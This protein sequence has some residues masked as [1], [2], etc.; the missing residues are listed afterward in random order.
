MNYKL[1]IVLGWISIVLGACSTSNSTP[2][3]IKDN[4]AEV[5][6]EEPPKS[7]LWEITGN[8]LADASYLFG[9][10]HMIDAEDYFLPEG[11]LSAIDQSNKMV[12]ELNMEEVMD[13]ANM[14][15]VMQKAFMKGDTSLS[16]LLT[17]EEYGVVEAHFK[18]K[19]LPLFMF[20]RMRP[21]FLTIFATDLDPTGLQS[22]GLK[23]YEMEFTEMAKEGN[24]ETGGLETIDYQISVF[25]A[26]PY[27]DQA[28]MLVEAIESSS[29][30]DSFADL[31]ALYKEQD[32]YGLYEMMKT[33]D[34]IG[35]FE[36][37]LL[38]Q[39]NKNWIPLME[40]E[41][42]EQRTFFAVGAGHLGGDLGVISLLRKAG[43]N[44]RPV[45]S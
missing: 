39:R 35:D 38:F 41:M 28:L 31:V 29:D 17:T 24:K 14:M 42:K 12:F 30:S 27:R 15:G 7:L 13:P 6:K 19:G 20:E 36:D 22:G 2:A 5:V 43:Y 11:T 8:G 32:I 3:E 44:V 9:T 4:V 33:D 16:D 1:L 10:I 37:V 26:I 18:E 21:M 23:S 45:T 25:D 34:S 40:Q